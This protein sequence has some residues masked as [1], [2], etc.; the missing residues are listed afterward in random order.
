[1]NYRNML[2][3]IIL[4]S[5]ATWWFL[6]E[7]PEAE[8]RGA[9]QELSRLLSNEEGAASG[10]TI[11]NAA[12]MKSMFAAICEVTGDAEMLA[13]AY[14]PEEMIS[15]I[16]RVQGFFRSVELTFHELEITFPAADDAIANFTA[17]LVAQVSKAGEEEEMFGETRTVV[18][19]MR[20]VDGKWL[21][22]EF[23]LANVPEI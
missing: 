10:T 16:V 1:M 12:V 19:R 21:F 14:T 13:G 9:H 23:S 2:I 15:T 3:I 6:H 7:D 17:V 22:A 8:V 5:A 20:K 18:S 11:L 4:L